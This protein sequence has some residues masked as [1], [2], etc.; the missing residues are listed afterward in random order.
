MS[1]S[2]R[3]RLVTSTGWLSEI[4]CRLNSQPGSTEQGGFP[5]T[6][7]P[8]RSTTAFRDSRPRRQKYFTRRD[9]ELQQVVFYPL[10][11]LSE[12]A[13]GVTRKLGWWTATTLYSQL[14]KHSELELLS[15]K[16]IFDSIQ[17][18]SN[19]KLSILPMEINVHSLVINLGTNGFVERK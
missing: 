2:V 7:K 6:G 4:R 9:N 8:A 16:T 11:V 5:D 17:S 10:F 14:R 13:P 18:N 12:I 3:L 19:S 1:P 15:I